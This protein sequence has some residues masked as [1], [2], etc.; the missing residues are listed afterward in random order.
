VR[1]PV[2]EPQDFEVTDPGIFSFAPFAASQFYPQAYQYSPPSNS[3]SVSLSSPS[4]APSIEYISSPS[5]IPYTPVEIFEHDGPGIFESPG[6]LRDDRS[7]RLP[8]R[9]L[10][11]GCSYTFPTSEELVAHVNAAHLWWATQPA[12]NATLNT[13]DPTGC[14]WDHCTTYPTI[15]SIPG[16]SRS[17]SYQ[18]L[19][20]VLT[21]HLIHDH[22][23][24]FE[25]P[26]IE[27]FS[28]NQQGNMD[29][30]L[31]TNSLPTPEQ[32]MTC[33]LSHLC[34]WKGCHKAFHGCSELHEHLISEHL[35]SGKTRYE[36]HW[37]ACPRH[38]DRGFSSK[39]KVLR[40]LQVS[41]DHTSLIHLIR[42][43]SY[44]CGIMR[45]HKSL[46]TSL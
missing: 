6:P 3:A 36:C 7:M 5:G 35:G 45:H 2:C 46:L 11:N 4:S 22:L 33:T 14:M 21:E 34:H 41:S 43:D 38:G 31:A 10:W 8:H 24:L 32:E 9:C 40:H 28:A 27:N 19:A 23:G 44:R 13:A 39:Q 42:S 26:A 12:L 16:T 1:H 15:G 29:V 25:N 20:T 17:T 18:P 37:D 30:D